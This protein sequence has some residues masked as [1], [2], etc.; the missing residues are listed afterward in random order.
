MIHHEII[1]LKFILSTY[2]FENDNSNDSLNDNFYIGHSVLVMYKC[3]SCISL[4]ILFFLPFVLYL[5]HYLCS[6]HK[7]NIQMTH[8]K[9]DK[10]MNCDTHLF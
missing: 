5:C 9:M 6:F 4:D 7:L 8:K 1:N 2:A 3:V 10:L